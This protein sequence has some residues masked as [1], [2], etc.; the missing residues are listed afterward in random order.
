MQPGSSHF[1]SY[2]HKNTQVTLHA[3]RSASTAAQTTAACFVH[4]RGILVSALQQKVPK[5]P[6]KCSLVL[7]DVRSGGV[8]GSEWACVV[9]WAKPFLEQLQ[10]NLAQIQMRRFKIKAQPR[11]Q[12]HTQSAR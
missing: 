1:Q 12:T 11:Q 4:T 9:V 6:N 5:Q 10:L 2:T 7:T 8:A 3:T